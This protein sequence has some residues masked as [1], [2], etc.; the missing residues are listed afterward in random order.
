TLSGLW[1][2][3]DWKAAETELRRLQRDIAIAA[4]RRDAE[5]VALA[6]KKLV[7][8]GEVKALAVRHVCNKV[9]Q[10]GIDN[11]TWETDE[12]KMRAALSLNLD[13]YTASPM[14]L[15]VVQP[16][17]S[18]KKRHIQI[19][20]FFDR[21]MQTLYSFALDPVAES[22][23]DRKS[24]A[25]R[26]GR[27]FYDV[28][29]FIISAFAGDNPPKYLI[30]ADV[31]SCYASI[32]HDWLLN[33]IPMDSKV[34][35]EFL[36]AGHF[37]KGEFFPSDDF[38]IALGL[39]ISPILANMTLDGAQE[40]V[41]QGLHGRTRDIDF[42]DGNLIRFADDILITARTQRSATRILQILRSFLAVRGL[43]LSDTKTKTFN[44]SSGFDFLSRH[45]EYSRFLQNPAVRLRPPFCRLRLA[46][47]EC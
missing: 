4:N 28:H 43:R 30:K 1:Q 35:T 17:G 15:I 14:R 3:V 44:I 36:K 38:G 13:G 5:A 12:Q 29:A 31:K 41:F 6:Q 34:L 20:T 27:S 47:C 16:K 33:N 23:G 32:S 24:F 45:Y 9:A 21:A 18:L 7:A 8:S 46:N 19:P 25:F 10:P 42:A 26:K 22:S 37:F 11:T 2:G 39:S 40:A